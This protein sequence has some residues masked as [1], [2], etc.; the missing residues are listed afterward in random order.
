MYYIFAKYFL[1]VS[2]K[3]PF[4]YFAI[5]CAKVVRFFTTKRIILYHKNYTLF[6]FLIIYRKDKGERHKQGRE[7]AFFCLAFFFQI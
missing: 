1:T 2:L 3:L 5:D 6:T 4:I 7:K